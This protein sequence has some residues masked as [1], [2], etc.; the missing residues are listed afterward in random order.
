EPP[1]TTSPH[2]KPSNASSLLPPLDTKLFKPGQ[3]LERI[4]P[5]FLPPYAP[6]HNPVGHVWNTANYHIANIQHD[7]PEE[8]YAA[9]I[10]YITG[11]TFNYD[12]EHLLNLTP[13]YDFV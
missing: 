8:T 5:I 4:T 13:T 10:S 3:Q 2:E 11:R 7:T 6:D 9:F 12:F 1:W